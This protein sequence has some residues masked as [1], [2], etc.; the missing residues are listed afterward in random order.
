MAVDRFPR[1]AGRRGH[2]ARSRSRR[3]MRKPAVPAPA[4]ASD[5]MASETVGR[6]HLDGPASLWQQSGVQRGHPPLAVTSAAVRSS[7]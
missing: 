1:Q 5:S 2:E 4:A 6:S 3:G 7:C